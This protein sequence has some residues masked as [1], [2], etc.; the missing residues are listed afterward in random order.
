MKAIWAGLANSTILLSLQALFWAFMIVVVGY[1]SY[2][3]AFLFIFLV[4]ILS[5][6]KSYY[7]FLKLFKFPNL[8]EEYT[9][10]QKRKEDPTWRKQ[11]AQGQLFFGNLLASFPL[12]FGSG[13]ILISSSD[14]YARYELENYGKISPA[15]VVGKNTYKER[16]ARYNLSLAYFCTEA[17]NDA[18][19][20]QNMEVSLY[21]YERIDKGDTV[22][23][24]HS[25]RNCEVVELAEPQ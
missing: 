23:V 16:G 10:F 1:Y 6:F 4:M 22:W 9:R 19:T 11:G 24:R 21:F 13:F 18:P 2:T 7:Y 15:V 12:F 8:D 14:F 25:T 17:K 20:S 3:I 5:T